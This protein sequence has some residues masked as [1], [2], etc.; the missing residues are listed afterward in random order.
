MEHER[1]G[2][3]IERLAKT[4]AVLHADCLRARVLMAQE[5]WEKRASGW[6]KSRLPFAPTAPSPGT[7][8]WRWPNATGRLGNPDQ[9]LEAGRHAVECDPDSKIGRQGLLGALAA[10]GKLD[11]AMIEYSKVKEAPTELRLQIGH[12]LIARGI[13][14]PNRRGPGRKSNSS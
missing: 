11:L 13:R 2:G 5:K 6:Q 14:L 4:G 12:L 3:V 7:P 10:Q 9:W 1:A 8:I